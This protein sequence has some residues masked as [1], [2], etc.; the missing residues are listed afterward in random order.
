MLVINLE[1]DTSI[2][3]NNFSNSDYL[4]LRK[5]L[6]EYFNDSMRHKYIFLMA[7]VARIHLTTKHTYGLYFDGHHVRN[8][9]YT[10]MIGMVYF[11]NCN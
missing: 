1:N 7:S 2:A 3:V 6:L 9:G 4:L 11:R 8:C 10:P 5:S